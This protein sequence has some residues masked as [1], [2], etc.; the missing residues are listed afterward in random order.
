LGKTI[1]T[2]DAQDLVQ[3]LRAAARTAIMPRFRCLEEGAIR[4]KSGPSD[5]VTVA[6]EEAERLI[7]AGL[8][9]RF[10]GAVVIGEEATAEDP[11]LQDRLA[12]ADLAFVVDP[13]DGT[14]NFV[15]GVPL[16]GVMAAALIGGEVVASVIHDPV[17]DDSMVAVRGEGAWRERPDGTR[18]DLRVA[19]PVPPEQM[20]GNASWRHLDSPL[21]ERVALNLPRV[22]GSWDY[23]CAAHAY[24]VLASGHCHFLIFNRLMPWDHLPGW[25]LH[26][27]AGGY[28]AHFDGTPYQ[29]TD[30]EGGLLYAPDEEGWSKLRETLFAGDGPLSALRLAP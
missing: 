4:E 14:S 6:D 26:R 16:F 24:R 17:V 11:S 13:I 1:T 3:M 7:T 28:A 22:Q 8:Q 15:A 30:R 29:A 12:D 10:P 27:E 2:A 21:R 23:R 25:L 9:R 18:T 19:A 5:L 20:T